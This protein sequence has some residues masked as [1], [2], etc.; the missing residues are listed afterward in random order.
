MGKICKNE[1]VMSK[2]GSREVNN[3]EWI[4]CMWLLV[5]CIDN[6]Y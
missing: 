1:E 5:S 3:S 2:A 4:V 6:I